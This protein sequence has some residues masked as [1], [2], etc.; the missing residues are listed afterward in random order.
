M[1]GEIDRQF[2][3]TN[4]LVYA[5]DTSSGSKHI[6]AKTLIQSLW[7]SRTGSISIQVLQEFYT[8][9]TQKLP[10]P[11]PGAEV[12]QIITS[13]GKWH[14]H[15]PQVE[16]VLGAIQVQERYNI[17]FWDAMIIQSA[18]QL[19]CGVLWSEDL[20]ADQVYQQVRV[21]NPFAG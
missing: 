15:T 13:L 16:D 10:R 19:G 12:A 17:S 7:E 1:N 9:S 11:L 2:V 3:D 21:Q 4:I 5:H 14:V 20:N 6:Q 18:N 8:V